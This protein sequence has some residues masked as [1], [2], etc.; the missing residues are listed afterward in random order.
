V[1]WNPVS[2]EW[3]TTLTPRALFSLLSKR[4]DYLVH[5]GILEVHSSGSIGTTEGK[6]RP[7]ISADFPVESWESSDEAYQRFVE[8]CMS[9]KKLRDFLGPD[10]DSWPILRR[11]WCIPEFPEQDFLDVAINT[12]QTLGETLSKILLH[13]GGEKLDTQM[14]CR[15][16]PYYVRSK[17]YSQEE[18][19]RLVDGIDIT[20]GEKIVVA[21]PLSAP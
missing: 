19:F 20:T 9:D 5:Q 11:R 6:K 15:H 12:W 14:R 8:A 1:I 2:V 7:K 3:T 17:E 16:D 18:F 4:R 21:P 10:C 13:I